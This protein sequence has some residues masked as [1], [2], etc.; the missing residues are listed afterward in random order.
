MLFNDLNGVLIG[1]H[2]A[3]LTG[4]PVTRA[5]L[6]AQARAWPYYLL[7]DA[8]VGQRPHGH[9][10]GLGELVV[11]QMVFVDGKNVATA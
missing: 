1:A 6:A 2:R 10:G 5:P 7:L 4:A 8:A 3:T 11:L 9:R